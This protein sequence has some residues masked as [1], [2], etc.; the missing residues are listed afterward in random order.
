MA[1]AMPA[2]RQSLSVNAFWIPAVP[3]GWKNAPDIRC[4]KYGWKQT[5]HVRRQQRIGNQQK[6][7]PRV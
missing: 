1:K 4:V 3:F 5:V 2:R 6:N 7:E